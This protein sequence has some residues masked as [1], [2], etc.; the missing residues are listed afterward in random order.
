VAVLAAAVLAAVVVVV[1][2]GTGTHR[3]VSLTADQPA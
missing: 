1:V 3:F 2:V